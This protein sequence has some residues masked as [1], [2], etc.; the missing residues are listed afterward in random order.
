MKK[1]SMGNMITIAILI[2]N[3]VFMG[4]VMSK[5]VESVK[6]DVVVL[7]RTANTA[8]DM[9]TTNDKKIAVI[10]S[11]IEQGFENLEKLIK[12]GY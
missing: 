4:A 6:Q 9:A 5:D 1:I 10:E 7:G 8:K 2:G 12:N 3:F 11:K